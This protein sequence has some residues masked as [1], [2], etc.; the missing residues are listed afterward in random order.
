MLFQ[1][2]NNYLV[3]AVVL[4]FSTVRDGG[5]ISSSFILL[6]STESVLFEALRV[7]HH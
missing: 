7:N 1:I 3:T 2:L 5:L 6:S 4:E